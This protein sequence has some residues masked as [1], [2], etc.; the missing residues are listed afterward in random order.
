MLQLVGLHRVISLVKQ[1][2][3]LLVR[4]HY[5]PICVC[6]VAPG[7]GGTATIRILLTSSTCAGNMECRDNPLIAIG[8]YPRI[9][10]LMIDLYFQKNIQD[11]M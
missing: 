2:F 7:V 3:L 1:F 9:Q 5:Q 8:E 4:P 6:I 10:L 11:E